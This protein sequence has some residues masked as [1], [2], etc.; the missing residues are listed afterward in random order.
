MTP[1]T[2]SLSVTRLVPAL[3]L[4]AAV[5]LTTAQQTQLLG[6]DARAVRL[7]LQSGLPLPLSPE[8]HLRLRASVEIAQALLTLYTR[9]P[10]QWFTRENS[11]PPFDGRTP[12]AYV[13]TGGTAALVA[14][15]RLLL[16][17]LNGLFSTSLESRALASR[18]PQPDIE[19]DG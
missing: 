5:G 8:Q 13:L 4:L 10:E 17:D 1:G 11:R 14:T 3:R 18:L 16:A 19:L 12:L 6:L 9:H 7:A 2:S 15:H